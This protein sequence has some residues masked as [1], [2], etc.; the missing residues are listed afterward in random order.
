VGNVS[1][2]RK[3]SFATFTRAIYFDAELHTWGTILRP[4]QHIRLSILMEDQDTFCY[5]RKLVT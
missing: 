1:V 2:R 4:F 5:V 3:A